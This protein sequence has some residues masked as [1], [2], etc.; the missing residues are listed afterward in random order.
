MWLLFLCR[1][2][3]WEGWTSGRLL[4][5]QRHLASQAAGDR[6]A[7]ALIL[8]EHSPL[9]TIGR[10]GSL[11]QVH[12]EPEDLLARG[13]RVQWV[14]R[15]G[16]CLLHL[17]GQVSFYPIVPLDSLGLGLR[18]YLERLH[19]VVI[20]VL[21]DFRIPA[22]TRPGRAGIWVEP[23]PVA[24]VGVAVCDWVTY[25]GAVL[26]VHPNLEP[27]RHVRTGPEDLPMTSLERERHGPLR[28]S[29]V[30]ERFVEHFTTRFG[31]GCPS[32]FFHH[33]TLDGLQVTGNGLRVKGGGSRD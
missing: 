31:F 7:S 22:V 5:L 25:F 10:E 1:S 28:V 6:K 8:C 4:V 3:C 9:I 13:W 14:N 29:M 2:I 30:R 27:F 12:Y 11:A 17:P 26:N 18:E 15:G 24:Q 16:G 33:P 23:R 20:D 32:I 21:G 19:Q